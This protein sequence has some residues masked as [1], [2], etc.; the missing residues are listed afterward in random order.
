M[1]FLNFDWP[2]FMDETDKVNFYNIIWNIISKT[3]VEIVND[4]NAGVTES[5][6]LLFK[7]K[8]QDPGILDFNQFYNW[9]H[10]HQIFI[11]VFIFLNAWDR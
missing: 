4:I 2:L 5:V 3:N 9:K 8:K 1:T 7:N 11:C 6:M 10:R